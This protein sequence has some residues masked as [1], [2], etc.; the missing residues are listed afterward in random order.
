MGRIKMIDPE[1]ASPEVKEAIQQHL[2]QGYKLTNE[3]K[4]LLHII[5]MNLIMPNH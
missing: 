1:N 4:T 3:K 2:A 5:K